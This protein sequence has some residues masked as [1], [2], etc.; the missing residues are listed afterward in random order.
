MISIIPNPEAWP[1]HKELLEP[2]AEKAGLPNIMEEGE[3]LWG[4]FRWATSRFGTSMEL[5][6]CVTTR[7][8]SDG[9]AE[10][11]LVAGEGQDWL[12]GMLEEIKSWAR[13]EG[14]EIIHCA[15]RK[16]WAKR[17]GWEPV[18][19]ENDMYFYEIRV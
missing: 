15:G 1:K 14:A 12:P 19:K 3:N 8:L 9:D 11:I 13:D 6:G 10:I 4:A 5:I 18:K 7:M 2:L 16:G 17:F